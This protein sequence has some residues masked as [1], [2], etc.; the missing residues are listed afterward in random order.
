[1]PEGNGRGGGLDAGTDAQIPKGWRLARLG[2]VADMLTTRIR[3]ICS[4]EC[5]YDPQLPRY[6]RITDITDDGR[7]KSEDPRSAAPELAERYGL[8]PGDLLFARSGS[9]GRTYRHRLGSES[10]VFAGYLIRFRPLPK[11]AHPE[12]LEHWTHSKS[13]YNWVASI[14]R[15]G[16][17]TNI[18]C[19][20]IW[21]RPHP[22]PAPARTAGHRR[23]AGRH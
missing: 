2:D 21:D 19:H 17:Q 5:N 23:R 15:R 16:A 6:I 9:V 11:V 10:C 4:G 18:K 13:Y 12:Y 7:L 3:G 14:A 22:P 20:R 8:K 1:M